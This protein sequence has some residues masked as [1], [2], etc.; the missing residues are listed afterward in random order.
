M[1]VGG[2]RSLFVF[3]AAAQ[4]PFGL[5]ADTQKRELGAIGFG[6]YQDRR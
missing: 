4:K 5:L 2:E 6:A 3:G 1:K